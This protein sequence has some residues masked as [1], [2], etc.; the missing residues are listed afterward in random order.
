MRLLRSRIT[1]IHAARGAARTDSYD[2]VHYEH[3][4]FLKCLSQIGIHRTPYGLALYSAEVIV[5]VSLV[6]FNTSACISASCSLRYL[7]TVTIWLERFVNYGARAPL[8]PLCARLP[9]PP[10]TVF[11]NPCL[12]LSIAC[13]RITAV[14]RLSERRSSKQ[15][16]HSY[17]AFN[18]QPITPH[19][20]TGP[21][22]S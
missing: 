18:L 9:S 4:L 14:L 5:R 15:P 21:G 2:F 1:A 3:K 6:Y 8:L 11:R 13:I 7:R 19:S 20:T 16:C 10:S 22:H 17:Y 12:A